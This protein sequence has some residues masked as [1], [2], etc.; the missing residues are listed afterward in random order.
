MLLVDLYYIC[1]PKVIDSLQQQGEQRLADHHY[2]QYEISAYAHSGQQC[3]HNVNYWQFGDY[4]GIGAGAH[5]KITTAK[6]T[7]MRTRK[8]KQPKSYLQRTHPLI[9]EKIVDKHSLAFEYML[10]A[11]RLTA[12]VN[13]AKFSAYTKLTVKSI[14]LPLKRAEEKRFIR[15][16]DD[17]IEKTPLGQ[18][19]LNDLLGLFLNMKS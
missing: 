3:Q 12:P 15:I 13:L 2:Q 16:T 6:N 11:L 5:G 9:E 4:L 10:N 14:A 19:F 7:V 18:R 17:T 1:L 8:V